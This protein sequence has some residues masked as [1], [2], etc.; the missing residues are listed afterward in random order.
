MNTKLLTIIASCALLTACSASFQSGDSLYREGKH[1]EA[2]KIL[3]DYVSDNPQDAL[4]H[5]TLADSLYLKYSD[6]YEK[7]RSNTDDLNLSLVHFS[8]AIELKPD[9]AEAY[10][11]R[12]VVRLVLGDEAGAKED[13]EKAIQANPALDRVYFNR[14]YWYE[15]QTRFPEAIVDYKRYI[16]LSNNNKW[17]DDAARRIETLELKVQLQG[18]DSAPKVAR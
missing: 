12:G 18:A 8:K 9:Y 10:S 4:G 3:E 15:K 14:A 13:Y 5:Y 16:A 11:Q 6:D 17:R 2:V 1:A 7:N